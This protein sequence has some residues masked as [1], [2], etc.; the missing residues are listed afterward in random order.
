[1]GLGTRVVPIAGDLLDREVLE[2]LSTCD[3]LFRCM[4]SVDGRHVLNK[5]A[6]A[7]VIPLID[8]GVRLDA[9]G[10]G[11]IDAGLLALGAD[12]RTLMAALGLLVAATVGVLAWRAARRQ[13][14]RQRLAIG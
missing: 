13:Q 12:V 9:D 8:V 14:Q 11:G 1:M 6:S 5:L 3:V 4:D 10:S 2:A 7:Y